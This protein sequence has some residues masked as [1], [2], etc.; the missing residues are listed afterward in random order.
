MQLA[1]AVPDGVVDGL[2]EC[3]SV[4]P[5]RARAA[6]TLFYA[7][8]VPMPNGTGGQSIASRGGVPVCACVC[9]DMMC[10]D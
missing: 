6:R 5:A 7:A 4:A 9:A 3:L 1:V 8:S 10:A 2:L